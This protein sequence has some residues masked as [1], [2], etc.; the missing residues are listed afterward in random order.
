MSA[1]AGSACRAVVDKYGYLWTGAGDYQYSAHTA[2]GGQANSTSVTGGYYGVLRIPVGTVA[3]SDNI[4]GGVPTFFPVGHETNVRLHSAR[5]MLGTKRVSALITSRCKPALIRPASRLCML[6]M[7][8]AASPE[9][10][11]AASQALAL[12]PDGNLWVAG[13]ASASIFPTDPL[14]LGAGLVNDHWGAWTPFKTVALPAVTTDCGSSS[15]LGDDAVD[16]CCVSGSFNGG[17]AVDKFTGDVYVSNECQNGK[18][19]REGLS[20]TASAAAGMRRWRMH[21]KSAAPAA[22]SACCLIAARVPTHTQYGQAGCSATAAGAPWELN[23]ALCVSCR[24]PASEGLTPPTTPPTR[25]TK[26]SR[27]PGL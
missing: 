22:Q 7:T 25:S 26:S 4:Q 12:S 23:R 8:S 3:G 10:A 21:H 19:S 5:P 18:V 1:H 16:P 17:I 27:R 9:S 24:W 11:C 13:A 15:G 20:A 14:Q 6:P 2:N